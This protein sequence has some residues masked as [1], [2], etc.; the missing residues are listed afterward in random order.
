MDRLGEER[1][2]IGRVFAHRLRDGNDTDAESLAQELLVAPGLDL[3][4]RE[5]G[6]VEHEH[7]VETSLGGVG[8]QALELGACLGLAPAGVEVAVFADQLQIGVDGELT[9]RLPLG[10]GGEALALLLG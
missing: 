6:G 8:H 10:V 1:G 5:A 2:G 9:D 7:H 3:A 4:A